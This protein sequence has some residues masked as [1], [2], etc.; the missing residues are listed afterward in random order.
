VA[1]V[2]VTSRTVSDSVTVADSATANV[3]FERVIA[4]AMTIGDNATFAAERAAFATDTIPV[5]DSI[6]SMVILRR[7]T[8]DS[9]FAS[10]TAT[11]LESL[12]R[13]PVENISIS[14]TAY[15][16]LRLWEAFSLAGD[17]VQGIN[18]TQGVP[19]RSPIAIS[20]VLTSGIYARTGT[21]LLS[22]RASNGSEVADTDSDSPIIVHR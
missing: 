4:D 9:V 16:R 22:T 15:G 19:Q 5:S 2:G 18:A 3:T 14:D 10:D 12:F 17:V 11:K 21:L 20:G 1:D 13:F 7:N 8:V 6:T